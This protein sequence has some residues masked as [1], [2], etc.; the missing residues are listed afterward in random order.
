MRLGGFGAGLT[1]VSPGFFTGFF[2]AGFAPVDVGLDLVA[3]P[4]VFAV[5]LLAE[6]LP[7]GL[8]AV[9]FW[10]FLLRAVLAG[11][12]DLEATGFAVLAA[13]PALDAAGFVLVVVDFAVLSAGFIVAGFV[14]LAA[15]IVLDAAGFV[16]FVPCAAALAAGLVIV[17]ADFGLTAFGFDPLNTSLEAVFFGPGFAVLAGSGFMG[18]GFTGADLGIPLVAAFFTTVVFEACF[19]VPVFGAVV[20]GFLVL[21]AGLFV[22]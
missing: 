10:V 20:L 19:D 16:V 8:S 7:A 21:I 5:V 6:G 22:P 2:G 17:A 9:V 12:L 14:V 1:L 3:E 18:A 13:T 4:P 15:V 11:G